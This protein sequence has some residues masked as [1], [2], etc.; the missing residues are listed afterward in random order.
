MKLFI[1]SLALGLTLSLSSLCVTAKTEDQGGQYQVLGDWQV[2]YIAF[3]STFLQPT[4]AKAY[5]LT[6][7]ENKAVINISVLKNREGTPAQQVQISGNAK[8]LL[9]N[10][11]ELTFKEVL[12]GEAIYYLAELDFYDEDVY[13]F[14]IT[15]RKDNQEQTLRFQQKLYAQ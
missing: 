2:H 4:I 12:E 8:N 3:P 13:R 14:T 6:R 9:G 1:R 10:G 15:I 11:P 7:D 5:G